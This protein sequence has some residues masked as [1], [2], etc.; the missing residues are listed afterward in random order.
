MTRLVP[1]MVITAGREMEESVGEARSVTVGETVMLKREE[2]ES[3]GG[4]EGIR[5]RG[6]R[7]MKEQ[8]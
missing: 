6:R 2:E 1:G 7:L 3:G 5:G 8:F 4:T